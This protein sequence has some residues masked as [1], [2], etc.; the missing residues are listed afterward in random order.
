MN[1]MAPT[2]A[3]SLP[4]SLADFQVRRVSSPRTPAQLR[5]RPNARAA[6]ALRRLA[7]VNEFSRHRVMLMQFGHG[8]RTEVVLYL[9]AFGQQTW[10]GPG[11]LSDALSAA[12]QAVAG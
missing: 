6:Q 5:L 4:L 12:D 1:I 9:D 10:T 2:P 3:V 7:G 8:Q 11:A